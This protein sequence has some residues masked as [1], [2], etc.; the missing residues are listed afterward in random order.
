MIY[1]HRV[2]YVYVREKN[3][4]AR[5][6]VVVA[7]YSWGFWFRVCGCCS[8]VEPLATAILLV[9]WPAE[10]TCGFVLE[11]EGVVLVTI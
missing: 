9:T 11:G 8:V 2:V 10:L 7:T 3:C 4:F 6:S 5:N 1:V